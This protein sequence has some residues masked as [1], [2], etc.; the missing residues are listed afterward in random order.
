ML[1]ILIATLVPAFVFGQANRWYSGD[2]GVSP[3]PNAGEGFGRIVGGIEAQRN[4]F[5][6][7]VQLRK[8]DRHSCGGSVINEEWIITAAHCLDDHIGLNNLSVAVRQYDVS[9]LE[10][11]IILDIAEYILH[12]RWPI[13]GNDI[14]LI[15]V[16]ERLDFSDGTVAPVCAPDEE[17]L[18]VGS[19]SVVSGWGTTMFL[20]EA[21]EILLYTA[22][23]VTT[24][25]YC[26]EALLANNY[27]PPR[28]KEVCAGSADENNERD[29]CQG[30]SGG[31]LVVKED[32]TF[33]LIGVVAH[34]F[35]CAMGSPG[36][37]TRVNNF[38]DWIDNTIA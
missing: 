5:P 13:P 8:W 38:L 24:N 23:T 19:P 4:E 29:S 14:A 17:R 12:P 1:S 2:C 3:V 32:G 18:Y 10:D 6:Y 35:G 27:P 9:Q 22:L 15:R 21:S 31:P 37:Y 30:D 26:R 36:V 7:Q 25:E 20:G 33:R 28:A 11:E 16:A 34:G